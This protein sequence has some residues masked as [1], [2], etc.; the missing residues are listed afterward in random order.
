[1]GIDTK[2]EMRLEYE[3]EPRLEYEEDMRWQ[4]EGDDWDLVMLVALSTT[5]RF[6]PWR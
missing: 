4:C 6:P 2:D 3:H 5:F 1:M